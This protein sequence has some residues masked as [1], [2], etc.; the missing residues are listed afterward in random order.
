VRGIVASSNTRLFNRKDG[1]GK[2][3]CVPHEIA[4]QLG[5]VVFEEYPAPKD[6]FT[7]FNTRRKLFL[8]P[9]TARQIEEAYLRPYN[10]ATVAM[11]AGEMKKTMSG[12]ELRKQLLQLNGE[13]TKLLEQLEREFQRRIGIDT[14]EN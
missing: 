1:S 9:A 13:S 11:L 7:F 2:R 12:D 10:N 14:K 8:P 5:V 3:V 6:S 4:L